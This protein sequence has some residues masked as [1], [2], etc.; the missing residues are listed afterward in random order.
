M[1]R[2]LPPTLVLVLSIICTAIHLVTGPTTAPT[3]VRWTGLPVAVFGLGITMWGSHRFEAVGTNIKTF[4]DPD[5]LVTDG[6]FGWSRNP[7][8]LGFTIALSGLAIG[9]GSLV[10]ISAPIAFAVAS[11]RWY[12][13]FEEQKM[14]QTFKARY[15]DYTRHVRRWF[16]RRPT[17]ATE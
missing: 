14:R 15:D 2:L 6:L 10:G 4:D 13:P 1:Q 7:M 9:L 16:G 17:G 3:V 11:D 8:Y 5:L 12:I